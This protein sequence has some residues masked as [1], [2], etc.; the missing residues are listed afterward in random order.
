[1]PKS[2]DLTG[3]IFNKLTVIKK[4]DIKKSNR[5]AWHCVCECG[6]EVDVITNHLTSGHTGSCG[7]L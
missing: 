3:K 1:M 5:L 7:C 4:A 6:N 2:S